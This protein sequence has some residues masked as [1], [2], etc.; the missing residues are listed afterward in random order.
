MAKR[1]VSKETKQKQMEEV[2]QGL[3][4]ASTVVVV[5]Y[6]G[7]NVAEVTDLRKQ[8]RD[9]GVKME[10]VKN[11]ILRRAAAEAGIEGLDEFFTGPTAIIYSDDVVNPAK[12]TVDF[13]KDVEI[14]EIKGGLVE[15][16]VAD[17][18]TIK[19]VAAMPS[20]EDLLSMLLSVLQAPMRNTA[21]VLS[22]ANPAQKLVYA[23]N[24][25]IESQSA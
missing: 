10:V 2:A 18:D 9:N 3:K 23:L 21:S 24:G 16:Q 7:L 4:E 14:L 6:L 12:I 5:D 22:Q 1:V 15:G 11:T 20:R 13:A 25:V 17:L 19:A 8:L